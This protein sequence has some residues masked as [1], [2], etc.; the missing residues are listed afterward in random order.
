MEPKKRKGNGSKRKPEEENP[1][2][3]QPVQGDGKETSSQQGDKNKYWRLGFTEAGRLGGSIEGLSTC[4][5]NIYQGFKMEMRGKEEVQRKLKEP[6]H[7]QIANLTAEIDHLEKKIER[8]TNETIPQAKQ[9][10]K[11]FKDDIAEIRKNPQDIIGDDEGRAGLFISAFI[12]IFLT[13]YLFVFYSSASYSAFFK[14]FT[15]GTLGVANSIFDPNAVP[16]ALSEGVTEL[17]LILTIPFVFLGLGFLIHKFSKLSGIRRYLNTFFFLL[18]TFLF[19]V[20][21]AYEITDKIYNILRENDITGQMPAYSTKL[22]MTN[23]SFWLIIF[24]GLVVYLIWGFIFNFFMEAFGKRDKIKVAINEKKKKIR[25]EEKDITKQQKQ[26][27]KMN[28]EI[29]QKKKEIIN[30]NKLLNIAI[31]PLDDIKVYLNEF[32]RGWLRWFEDM[33][34]TDKEKKEASDFFKAFMKKKLGNKQSII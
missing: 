23:Y 34:K 33:E 5:Y 29:L 18:T 20:I 22:A 19:D 28:D 9:N 24:A 1:N 10:I 13:I 16:N 15:I 6:H 25:D 12:L 27:N 14:Q 4:L 31:I 32:F 26:I 8:A 21:I 30:L 17:I 3:D 7:I 11:T 2:R